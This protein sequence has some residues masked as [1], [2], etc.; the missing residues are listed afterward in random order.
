MNSFIHLNYLLLNLVLSKPQ[1]KA[2]SKYS[3]TPKKKRNT[4][5]VMPSN[6]INKA[7]GV[8]QIHS[9]SLLI[10]LI[11]LFGFSD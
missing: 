5:H 10:I 4:K 9:L 7:I 3:Y 2:L 1:N 11:I 8:C 6:R